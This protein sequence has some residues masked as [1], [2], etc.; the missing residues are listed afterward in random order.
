ME[1]P[2]SYTQ[3]SMNPTQMIFHSLSAPW[4]CERVREF[5]NEPGQTLESHLYVEYSG[6]SAQYVKATTVAHANY[7]ANVRALSVETESNV[8]HTDPWTEEQLNELIDIGV[9]GHR[10]HGIPLQLAPAW[11]AP[12]FGY[13]GM[14]PEWSPSGTACPGDVRIAQFRDIVFPGIVARA[15]GTE[16]PTNEEDMPDY[17][18]LGLKTPMTLPADG[19]FN[20]VVFENEWSDTAGDH[21]TNGSVFV[22]GPAMFDGTVNITIPDLPAGETVQVRMSEY[23][24]GD[25]VADHPTSD[26]VGNPGTTT[27]A[28]SITKRIGAGRGMRIRLANQSGAPVTVSGCVLA[29]LVFK[30]A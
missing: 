4:T 16:P 11:N 8:G 21:A 5:W 14:Y 30:E 23:A 6:R 15:T 3:D 22:Q 26:V 28:V 24:G 17:V 1:I 13:H 7:A 18:N 2:E 12:G 29:A 19:G 25:W 10:D 9:W 20:S 27:A